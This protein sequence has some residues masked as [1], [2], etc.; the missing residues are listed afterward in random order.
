MEAP[1][2]PTLSAYDFLGYIVPGLSFLILADASYRFHSLSLPFTYEAFISQYATLTWAN[3]VPLLLVAYFAGHMI[4]FASS[5]SIERHATWLHGPPAKVLL[6]DYKADYL[7]T[8]ASHS[9]WGSKLLRLSVF[10]F[11]L[12]ISIIEIVAGRWLKLAQNYIR[13]ADQLIRQAFNRSMSR[14]LL[15]IGVEVQ[16]IEGNEPW[17]YDL[18]RLAIHCAI[19]RAPAHVHTLRNYVVLFGFLRSMCLIL[20]LVFWI[21]LAHLIHQDLV[22]QAAATFLVGSLLVFLCYAAF[23]KFWFRYYYEAI[24]AIIA[25]A[26]QRAETKAPKEK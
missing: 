25:T 6:Y 18:E 10:L 19:E 22:W 8:R 21:T 16:H 17:E 11:L 1:K 2:A 15:S 3:L 12:P 13:P 7:E 20:V 5:V 23:L 24:M 4:S 9:P 26:S 14:L